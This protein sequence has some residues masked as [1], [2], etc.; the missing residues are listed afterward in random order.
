MEGGIKG[1]EGIVIADLTVDFGDFKCM[2]FV[3]Q[4]GDQPQIG[5]EEL[6]AVFFQYGFHVCYVQIDGQRIAGGGH[7]GKIPEGLAAIPA[8]QV[9][10]GKLGISVHTKCSF[11][12]LYR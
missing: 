6:E 10:G 4:T 7:F 9:N 8:G 5:R 12:A 1:R 11:C 3:E 2:L